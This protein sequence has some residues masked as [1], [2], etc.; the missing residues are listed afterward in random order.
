M[1]RIFQI[2][3]AL[4]ITCVVAIAI[5]VITGVVGQDSGIRITL[6]VASIIGICVVAALALRAVLGIGGGERS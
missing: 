3:V 6:N 4:I 5:L 1:L 2:G